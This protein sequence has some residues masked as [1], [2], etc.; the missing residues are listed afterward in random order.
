MKS[1]FTVVLAAICIVPAGTGLLNATTPGTSNNVQLVGQNP[2]FGRG[3]NAAAANYKNFLYVGNR[4]D[5]SSRCGFG[6]PRRVNGLDTCPHPHPGILIVDITNPTSPTVVG[7]IP[8]PVNTAGQPVG[9]T[10]R[11][12]RVWPQKK[13]LMTM[14]F[15]CSSL[16]HACPRTDDTTS[17][18]D[19]KFFSLKDPL[20]PQFISHYV[21]TSRVT[22]AQVKPHEMFLWVDPNN[23]NRAL[24]FLSTPNIFVDA[25]PNLLIVDISQVPSGAAVT[26]VTEGTWNNRF[27]GTNQANY[28]GGS[29]SDGCGPYDCNLFVHSMGLKPDGSVAYLALEAGHFLILDTSQVAAGVPNPQLTL[30]TDPTNRP[31]WLQDPLDPTAVPGVFPG[32]CARQGPGPFFN[33]S[34]KDCPNSHSAVQVPGRQLALTTDEV[35]GTLTFDNQG[36]RWGW[37]RLIDVSNPGRPFITGEYTIDE[38]NL[39]FCGTPADDAVTESTRSYSSH[40]PTLTQ[41]LAIIDWHSGG[42]QIIDTSDPTNPVQAGFYVPD[43]PSAVANED[44]A[45]SQG[46]A[47]RNNK[48]VFW[49]YPIIKNGLIYVIDVRNGLFIFKYTGPHADEVRQITFLE[50]NSNLGDAVDLDQ[51]QNSQ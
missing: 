39:S 48:T 16:L 13:L 32:G 49:S 9:I 1:R 35:Y 43:P 24:L 46:T 36:C 8:A 45:L 42:L 20:H 41:N 22:G 27:P 17:P 40:N 31:V 7:E 25:N 28:P 12:V 6:D 26:E 15:R 51:D 21:P 5:G 10:S 3:M 4:T 29:G 33:P 30:L 44:P 38:N 37:A 18:F 2:L 14:N 11:E 50:G 47:S 34:S 23:D 19:I